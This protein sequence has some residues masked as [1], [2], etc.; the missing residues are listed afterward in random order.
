MPGAISV[1]CSS[2]DKVIR[3]YGR[4]AEKLG[5]AVATSR[6]TLMYGGEDVGLMGVLARSAK[7]AG[8]RVVG[9]VTEFSKHRELVNF[10]ICDEIIVVKNFA[11]RKAVLIE[12]CDI[13]VALP[14]GMGT[15]DESLEVIHLRQAG[16]LRKPF[17]FLN[18]Y[19][20]YNGLR[21]F[22]L[23]LHEQGFSA[24]PEKLF[25]VLSSVDD[26]KPLLSTDG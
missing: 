11:E 4:V 9:V 2:S 3:R 17:C 21:D 25:Q 24:E 13:F 20:F 8:G 12:R 14:G 26:L 6:W 23:R 15:L 7:G 22:F 10:S 19:G 18:A 1:F 16:L 5:E